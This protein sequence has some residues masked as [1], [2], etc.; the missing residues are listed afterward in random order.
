MRIQMMPR[1]TEDD[2]N[3]GKVPCPQMKLKP[4]IRLKM[5]IFGAKFT[6][7][8]VVPVLLIQKYGMEQNYSAKRISSVLDSINI[9]S[10]AVNLKATAL[11]GDVRKFKNYKELYAIRDSFG[12]NGEGAF[13]VFKEYCG[14]E[15]YSSDPFGNDQAKRTSTGGANRPL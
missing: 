10:E 4:L 13:E 1:L 12:L 6:L 9:N 5:K 15:K 11:Y 8:K 2:T 14:I 7:T 3:A